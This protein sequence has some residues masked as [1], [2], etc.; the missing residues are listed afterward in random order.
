M[1]GSSCQWVALWHG[2]GLMQL[3]VR[4]PDPSLVSNT[5][6]HEACV[7][8]EPLHDGLQLPR[9]GSLAL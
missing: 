9:E 8:L 4:L 7:V 1:M 2:A 5:S 3:L 6:P